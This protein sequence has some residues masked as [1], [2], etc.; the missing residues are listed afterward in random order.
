MPDVI[1]YWP[2]TTEPSAVET[3][4]ANGLNVYPNPAKENIYVENNSG[5]T[6]EIY[7][8]LGQKVMSIAE[9]DRNA[10]VSVRGLNEGTYIV[11]VIDGTQVKTAKINVVK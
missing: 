9:A 8:L 5:A 10:V 11:K 7:N 1:L 6:I 4:D 3:V 2:T